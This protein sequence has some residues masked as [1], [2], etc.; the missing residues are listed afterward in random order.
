MLSI[1]IFRS[2]KKNI[3]SID[4]SYG[5]LGR[6]KIYYFGINWSV[7]YTEEHREVIKNPA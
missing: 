1:V 2:K 6:N 4:V 7:A 3:I 5:D